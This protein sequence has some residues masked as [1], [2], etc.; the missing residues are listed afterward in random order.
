MTRVL[1]LGGSGMLGHRLYLAARERFATTATVRSWAAL[2]AARSVFDR[3]HVIDG[4]D[5]SHLDS[6]VRA[7]GAARPDV[8]VNCVGL[9]KQ[10]EE[11]KDPLAALAINAALPHQLAGLCSATG[12][13][14]IHLSTDCVFSG[15]RG[16]YSED[17]RADADD[18]Y[19]RTKL[20]GEVS[21]APALTLRTSMIGRELGRGTG[22]LEWFLAQQTHAAGFTRAIFSGLTT[23]V[24]AALLVDLIEHQPGLHGL[25]H[26]AAEPISK[27]ELLRLAARAFNVP[28][29]VE[30]T[31]GAAVDRSLD[32]SKFARVARFV[33]PSWPVMLKELAED[34][35]PYERIR[36]GNDA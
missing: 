10:R 13:R 2:G 31:E 15:S 11:A 25:Y 1:I 29:V 34:P 21:T 16:R 30:P 5:A 19:G 33:A 27:C 8:V 28:T 12:S 3:S 4:I 26:V 14:L 9:V 6:V 24:L 35:L 23:P 22:L 18:L 7:F 20:L 32:G 17:D 36:N